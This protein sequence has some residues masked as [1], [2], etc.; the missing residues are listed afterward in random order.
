MTNYE[1]TRTLGEEASAI[2]IKALF[3][4]LNI[5]NELDAVRD[6]IAELRGGSDK[7]TWIPE[8]N[9]KIILK[10]AEGSQIKQIPFE[11]A[12]LFQPFCEYI[13]PKPIEFRDIIYYR[14]QAQA[15]L[16]LPVG[17]AKTYYPNNTI[18]NYASH[19]AIDKDFLWHLMEVY[20]EE[21]VIELCKWNMETGVSRSNWGLDKDNKPR[22]FDYGS[23]Q[24]EK[25]REISIIQNGFYY[26]DGRVI[27]AEPQ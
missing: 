5:D 26:E 18:K 4:G 17:D 2:R 13:L 14:V 15:L 25:W 22:I 27:G 8:S 19:K 3:D 9:S 11:F 7:V 1:R 16:K 21:F 23:V 24:N 20:N 12:D 6:R 10:L